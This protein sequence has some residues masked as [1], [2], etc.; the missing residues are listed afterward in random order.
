MILLIDSD[1]DFRSG[2]AANLRE[3][4]FEVLD[5]ESPGQLPPLSTL[6]R[7]GFVIADYDL[8]GEDGVQFAHRFHREHPGVPAVIVAANP[9][10][11]HKVRESDLK[12][13]SILHKPF[14]YEVLFNLVSS[15]ARTA[16]AR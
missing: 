8:P 1:E 10:L 16:A 11:H 14:E 5:L 6:G 12:H 13:L 3:D 9:H 7:V 15:T 4:G 2:L